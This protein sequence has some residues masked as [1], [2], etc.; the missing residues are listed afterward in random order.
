[1]INFCRDLLEPLQFSQ[2]KIAQIFQEIEK[3]EAR[4]E[5]EAQEEEV[6]HGGPGSS[7]HCDANGTACR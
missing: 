7:A 6:K 4:E 2:G 3:G 5:D 1:M